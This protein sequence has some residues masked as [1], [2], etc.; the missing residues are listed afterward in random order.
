MKETEL[1]FKEGKMSVNDV[2]VWAFNKPDTE[3]KVRLLYESVREGKSRFGWSWENNHNLKID[4]ENNWKN[5]WTKEHPK[6]LFL[7]SI[8]PGD[9]IVHIHMPSDGRCVAARVVSE[10]DFDEEINTSDGQDFRHFFQIDV[11]S[12][13]EFKRSS[14]KVHS[15]VNLYPRKRYN[16]VYAVEEFISS[17][18][19]IKD[20]REIEIE[21]S[22]ERHDLLNESD[23]ILEQIPC[24]I[25][26]THKGKK[27][28]SFLA[29]VIR[30]IPGVINV[31]ENGSSGGTDHGAD[32]IVTTRTSVGT[33]EIKNTIVVQV[34]SYKNDVSDTK[35]VDQI[36]GAIEHYKAS[37]GMIITTGE[38]TETLGNAVANAG[39]ELGCDIDLLAG[40]ELAQFVIR[41]APDQLF[42]LFE[43]GAGF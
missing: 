19:A 28:E 40:K 30:K 12:I 23:K 13:V 10:Y 1:E 14:K 7:L 9:W 8:R 41:Y 4:Q 39:R 35:A 3:E 37:A 33:L 5:N 26:R 11:E 43:Y 38:R 29:E 21:G 2:R 15:A 34:K 36:K 31:K 20:D 25:H 18:E 22:R 32:L 24:L 27:L 42:R 6:Q 17:I 16:R